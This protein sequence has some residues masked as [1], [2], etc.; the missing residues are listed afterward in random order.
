MAGHDIVV[1]GASAGGVE[2]LTSLVSDLPPNLPAAL[3]VVLHISPEGPSRLPE[4]LSRSGVLPAVHPEDG[5]HIE[6]GK[7]YIAPPDYHLL[8]E[9][10]CIKVIRGPKEN[11]HRAAIDPLFRSAAH[12]YRGR[13]A[14]VI[15]TGGLDDGTSGLF[16]IKQKGGIA[17]V[18]D[19]QEALY[20]SMP[21]SALAHVEIDYTLPLKKIAPLLVHTA[22]A[23]I[24]EGDL[25]AS[26]EVLR[27]CD[28]DKVT[29]MEENDLQ[30]EELKGYPSVFSCP[31]CGGVLWEMQSGTVQR[32]R[33][34]VGH[35]FSTE[36]MLIEQSEELDK[37][38]WMALKTLEEKVE[39]LQ[40]LIDNANQ[41]GRTWLAQSF[42]AR[43]KEAQRHA[44]IL[45]Q[46][47]VEGGLKLSDPR[48]A[49]ESQVPPLVE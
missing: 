28:E 32:F 14:G 20:P 10:G 15:L 9:Q 16:T 6:H 25:Q 24:S 33:C 13:V 26:Q 34:R 1:V 30:Q 8:L 27:E 44:Q 43:L 40:R 29:A 49:K 17:I 23:H 36:S 42:E 41:H 39:L 38:L 19:P 4:I 31:E 11:R 12:A 18:Q 35:A 47:L 3:F 7:I 5:E 21:R 22:F 2:A 48:L 46:L 45:R 37:T